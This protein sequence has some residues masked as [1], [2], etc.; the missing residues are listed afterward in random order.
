VPSKPIGVKRSV[1]CD[2][3]DRLERLVAQADRAGA[4]RVAQDARDLSGRLADGRFYVA[5][6]GQFKRG[7]STLI[8]ALLGEELLPV[9]VVPVT[10]VVTVVRHGERPSARVRRAGGSWE[11]IGLSEL[12]TFATE[13]Q[14]PANRLRVDALEVL[15]P[16]PLL[17]TGLCLVDTPGVGSVFAEACAAT[18]AFVPHVDAALVVI[19]GDPP[20]S[21]EEAELIE[22]VSSHVDSILVV[23]N[24]ADR[25]SDDERRQAKSFAGRVLEARLGRS[26]GTILEV[27]AR[28]RILRTGPERDWP[29]LQ[30]QLSALARERGSDL[31]G[32]AEERGATSLVDR[33]LQELGERRGALTRPIAESE[34]RVASLQQCAAAAERAISGLSYTFR[35][36]QDRLGAMFAR[37]R[38]DFLREALPR[39]TAEL[40]ARLQEPS[41]GRGPTLRRRA[42]ARAQE[43][44]RPWVERW[45]A[46]EQPVAERAYREASSRFVELANGFLAQLADSGEAALA[47]LPR[48]V[49]IELGFRVRSGLFYTE[50][51]TLTSRSIVH[52]IWDLVRP[53]ASLS[54]SVERSATHYLQRLLEANTARVRSDFD[55]RVL[56]SRRRLEAEVRTLI[57]EVHESAA[58]ALDL[59]RQRLAAGE[60]AVAEDLSRIDALR[61]AVFA[62]KREPGGRPPVSTEES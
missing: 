32:A 2:T 61:G 38:E 42:F 15:H 16:C 43:V 52:W 53:R 26:A 47:A 28:E 25:L 22:T 5:C 44:H 31:V 60:A 3:G 57:Q 29:K 34:R 37:R 46:A 9:G 56:E 50:M 8:N 49:G 14:N 12:A 7:K 23:L 10:T 30:E 35:A 54:K 48:S 18:R 11:P 4:S 13:E 58:R 62:L 24:K 33:L 36:E 45:R 39:A 21:G 41:L 51:M 1:D 19:G 40:V 17:A 59:V 55:E 6:L 20:L 27:S